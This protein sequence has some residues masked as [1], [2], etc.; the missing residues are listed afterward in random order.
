TVDDY[1]VG[2][3][4][5]PLTSSDEVDFQQLDGLPLILPSSAN[6]LREV[7]QRLARN[8]GVS[9][10]V[11]L[12]VDSLTVQKHLVANERLHTILPLHTVWEEVQKGELQAARIVSPGLS[13]TIV[14]ATSKTKGPSPAVGAITAQ[15]VKIVE[16]MA[17]V[18]LLR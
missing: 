13:R 14:M 15:V 11:P 3:A 16:D 18:G 6:G 2:P 7:L 1:L 17:L 9:L 4:G 12:E 5:D 10:D 8:A